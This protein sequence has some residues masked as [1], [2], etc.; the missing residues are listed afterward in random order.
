MSHGYAIWQIWQC[1]KSTEP[2]RIGG[3]QRHPTPEWLAQQITEAPPHVGEH[4]AVLPLTVV[5]SLPGF[6]TQSCGSSITRRHNGLMASSVMAVL[7][8]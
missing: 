7:L 6:S 1:R 3:R 4:L 5:R 8:S 2:R